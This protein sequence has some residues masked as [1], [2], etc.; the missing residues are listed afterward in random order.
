MIKLSYM[1]LSLT[2][3]VG[4]S[5]FFLLILIS[6]LGCESHKEPRVEV[7]EIVLITPNG[8]YQFDANDVGERVYIHRPSL[9]ID[10]RTPVVDVVIAPTAQFANIQVTPKQKESPVQFESNGAFYQ[11][12]REKKI[13][14]QGTQKEML[15][16]NGER[17]GSK[18][19]IDLPPPLSKVSLTMSRPAPY[20]IE[21]IEDLN[22]D[23]LRFFIPFRIDG[24][25]YTID[26][27]L[28]LKVE[29]RWSLSLS[30]GGLP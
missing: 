1:R 11:R 26:S 10:A 12:D 27:S 15:M 2:S 7:R 19:L 29:S 13:P 16:P 21:A 25:R 14:L 22:G 8:K 5:M 9:S 6:I 20:K 18:L 30:F 28:V 4:R 24:E 17:F 23:I 3:Y